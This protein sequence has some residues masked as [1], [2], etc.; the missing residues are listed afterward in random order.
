MLGAGA[1]ATGWGVA[2]GLVVAAVVLLVGCSSSS[3]SLALASAAAAAAAVLAVLADSI[4]CSWSLTE[5]C[6]ML[7]CC[8]SV[9]SESSTCITCTCRSSIVSIFSSTLR[10]FFIDIVTVRSVLG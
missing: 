1:D 5:G 6:S 3:F 7:C 4:V 10:H 8:S 2:A 9:S